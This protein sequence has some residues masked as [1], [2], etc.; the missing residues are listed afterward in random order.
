MAVHMAAAYDYLVET[1][2]VPSLPKACLGW[3]LVL[4]SVS[5]LEFSYLIFYFIRLYVFLLKC[6]QLCVY[7][8]SYVYDK[9]HKN[10]YSVQLYLELCIAWIFA[11]LF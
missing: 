8:I 9:C 1:N 2:F 5:S 6:P 11:V 4:N 3:D 7:N 10:S